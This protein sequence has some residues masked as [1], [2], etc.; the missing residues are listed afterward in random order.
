[1]TASGMHRIFK[2]PL[3]VQESKSKSCI[4]PKGASDP[5]IFH[6]SP[7]S[8]FA[9]RGTTLRKERDIGNNNTHP[10]LLI[11]L[12]RPL[13]PIS[14]SIHRPTRRH[15]FVSSL[16]IMSL[17]W[18]EIGPPTLE[19]P[20]GIALWPIFEHFSTM[21]KGYRPQDFDFIAGKTP[22][23]TLSVTAFTLVAY[24][25]TIFGGREI[26]RNRP[27]FELNGLFKIHNFYLVIIS[28]ALLALMLEQLIPELVTNGVFHGICSHD[29]GWT[30]QMVILYY[31]C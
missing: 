3:I 8:S 27:A 31:V 23:S 14:T 28:G 7:Q 11:L 26:M 16:H 19:R 22:M 1:M 5:C 21:I 15:S 9:S 20:F 10:V 12:P 18:L 6:I 2:L 4:K 13:T 25:I 29:G 17:K 24:Y 30:R